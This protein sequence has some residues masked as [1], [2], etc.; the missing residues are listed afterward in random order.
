M[1]KTENNNVL[2][3]G[4]LIKPFEFNNEIHGENFYTAKLSVKRDSGVCDEIPI[5]V[6]DRIADIKQYAVGQNL[7]ISGSF[8]S[9]NKHEETRNR[10]ILSVFATDIEEMEELP[11]ADDLNEIY[12]EGYIC[13]E[14][15][16]RT[17]TKGRE[18]GE[19]LLAVNR[20]YG[21]S[22]YIPCITWGRNARFT[23]N[24]EV[25]T[26][27]KI[28]GRIQSRLY[29]KL[30]PNGITEDRTAYE[31]SVQTFEVVNE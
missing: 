31:V 24:L 2:I 18:I 15:I 7:K 6:S 10:L 13:K 20:A 16:Y 11:F 3:S 29:K 28:K 17:T 26:K 25:G 12:L 9:Y 23:G 8:R 4:E 22:D 27:I 14:P 1:N 19:I 30:L 21:K 5:T